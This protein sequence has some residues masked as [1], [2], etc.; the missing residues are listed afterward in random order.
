[1]S[2]AEMQDI[3]DRVSYPG[4][5]F[6]VG[7]DAA[8]FSHSRPYLQIR[9]TGGVCN[10]T[11]EPLSWSSR[12]WF[13]SPHMTPSEV[14]QTAFKAAITAM[15]HELREQFTYRGQAIFGPHFDVEALVDMAKAGH[16]DERVPA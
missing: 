16:T 5:E 13:L 6:L 14:V 11:G 10:V 4:W 2:P 12:K 8:G 9:C 3:L 1:M 7:V 15:E